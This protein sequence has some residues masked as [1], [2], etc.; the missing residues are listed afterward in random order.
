ML[1]H[2]FLVL[3][4]NL[5][6]AIHTW[7]SLLPL[8]VIHSG[9][10]HRPHNRIADLFITQHYI[11]LKMKYTRGYHTCFTPCHLV[12]EAISALSHMTAV[13]MLCIRG[14]SQTTLLIFTLNT[15][16]FP[17]T[18]KMVSLFPFHFV[19]APFLQS[20]SWWRSSSEIAD[21]E[22]MQ[23]GTSRGPVCPWG[24]FPTLPAVVPWSSI[25]FC[26]GDSAPVLLPKR[27]CKHHFWAV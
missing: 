5:A 18:P 1:L 22:R 15:V 14:Q 4:P 2:P 25:S 8:A 23:W 27:C 16:L 20:D 17:R 3:R 21:R 13:S 11:I 9:C 7:T 24:L 12:Q 19:C 6:H 26:G 10:C